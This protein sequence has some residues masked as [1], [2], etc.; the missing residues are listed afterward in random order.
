MKTKQTSCVNRKRN[1]KTKKIVESICVNYSLI[2]YMRKPISDSEGK[3]FNTMIKQKTATQIC[4]SNR[5]SLK[6]IFE[7]ASYAKQTLV[8]P[9]YRSRRGYHIGKTDRR[10]DISVQVQ[11]IVTPV[12]TD[13][14]E[15]MSNKEGYHQTP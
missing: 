14:F 3:R 5:L 2:S 15:P 13:F 10:N 8:K 7:R 4:S 6:N 12:R 11:N 1:I 9:W